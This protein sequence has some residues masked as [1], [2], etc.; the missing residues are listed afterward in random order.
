MSHSVPR[1][2]HFIPGFLL[3]NFTNEDG[4][5]WGVNRKKQEV[6]QTTPSKIFRQRDLYVSHDIYPSASSILY[7]TDYVTREGELSKLEGL[8]A[9][10]VNKIIAS[11]RQ[12]QPPKLS[13]DEN[14]IFMEFFLSIYRRNPSRLEQMAAEFTDVYYQAASKTAAE[15]G[16]PLPTKDNLYEDPEII[17]LINL[18]KQNTKSRF[19][20]GDH[21]IIRD[22]DEASM[23]NAGLFIIN[24][25]NPKRSFI[26]GNCA[27][28]VKQRGK[29]EP[30]WLP[31][32]SGTAVGLIN[33]PGQ[34]ELIMVKP[35]NL[36][37]EKIN[38]INFNSAAQS[39]IFIGRSETLVRSLMKRIGT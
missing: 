23:R 16:Y 17:K 32:A 37:D 35:N 34:V 33:N 24:I 8:A 10:V 11:V 3:K 7:K 14:R 6:F 2:P 4:H 18:A 19:A 28:S 9:P 5:L 1:Q 36:N 30:E 15:T 25:L 13:Y 38:A 12:E 21:K 31:I 39:D 22:K 26:I 20:I 27:F 29:P